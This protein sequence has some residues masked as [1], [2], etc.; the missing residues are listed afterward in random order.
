MRIPWDASLKCRF[1]VE[2]SEKWSLDVTL[3]PS[4]LSLWFARKTSTECRKCTIKQVLNIPPILPAWNHAQKPAFQ[5]QKCSRHYWLWVTATTVLSLNIW[6]DPP[7]PPL[8]IVAHSWMHTVRIEAKVDISPDL[9]ASSSCL[10]FSTVDVY[11]FFCPFA[12]FSL[13]LSVGFSVCFRLSNVF[14]AISLASIFLGKASDET[15][16]HWIWI[17]GGGFKAW[18][19][20]NRSSRNDAVMRCHRLKEEGS[21]RASS[22]NHISLFNREF[23]LPFWFL[24]KWID[25]FRA[26]WL[27]L[28]ESCRIHK[29][30]RLSWHDHDRG[31]VYNLWPV[32]SRWASQVSS[33]AIQDPGRFLQIWDWNEIVNIF[34]I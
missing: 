19:A 18:N 21:L 8:W 30:W 2:C 25:S 34:I 4:P 5:L 20:T 32:V 6:L 24:G 23:L 1:P 29:I 31:S 12:Y 13:C 16:W 15:W 33:S 7:P 27:L 17:G 26:W 10:A 11:L 28:V 3:T 14:S 9:C 22:I